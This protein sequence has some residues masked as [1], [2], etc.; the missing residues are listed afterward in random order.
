MTREERIAKIRGSRWIRYAR[1][2]QIAAKLDELLRLPKTHRMP[3]LLIVG[4]TNNGKT[5]LTRR[6]VQQHLPTLGDRDT[7]SHIPVIAVQAPPAPDERRFYQAILT[8]VLE[9][10][11]PSHSLAQL[12]NEALRVLATVEVRLLIIDEIH[13]VLAGPFPAQA[14]A[15][16][17]ASSSTWAMSSRFRS[18]P[19][20]RTTPS[21][22]F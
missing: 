17:G 2:E 13:H 3:N 18:S 8:Q 7:L 19:P 5:A 11:R 10:F 4:E 14:A 12:Q 20:A 6:F 15:F 22:P 16:P 1:A 21:T 9:P